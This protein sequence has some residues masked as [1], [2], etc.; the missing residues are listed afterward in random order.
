MTIQ[1]MTTLPTPGNDHPA[2]YRPID[3][4]L[5]GDHSVHDRPPS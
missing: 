1:L 4:Q 5:A 2:D 3:D